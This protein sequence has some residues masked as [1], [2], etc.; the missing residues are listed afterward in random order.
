MT[1]YKTVLESTDAAYRGLLP[2]L[3]KDGFKLDKIMPIN[4]SRYIIIIG[5]PENSLVIF[6]KDF[7]HTFG[8][9]FKDQ[10]QSGVGETINCKELKKSILNNVSNIYIIY[11]N[12]FVYKI[13][14]N[15]FLKDSFKHKNKE[16]KE[17]RSISIHKLKR[18]Y[19]VV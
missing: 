7:F 16:G 5:E 2:L 10:G 14:L 3:Q 15:D 11:F 9:K 12:G 6:K 1:H 17:V 18:A 8:R 13:S 19:R 4:Q